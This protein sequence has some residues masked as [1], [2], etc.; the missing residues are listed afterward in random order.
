MILTRSIELGQFISVGD[1]L[2]TIVDMSQAKVRFYLLESDI[3][4]ASKGAQIKVEIPSLKQT[5]MGEVTLVAP[6]FQI[7][8]PGYMVEVSLNNAAGDFKP[9]MQAHV[10]FEH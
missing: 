7:G 8:E 3:G 2:Y 5:V 9:G 4:E 10:I 6:A 1:P